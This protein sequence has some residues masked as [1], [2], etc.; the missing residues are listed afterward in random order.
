M[1]AGRL[2]GRQRAPG[3][4]T[5]ATPGSRGYVPSAEEVQSVLGRLQSKPAAP[6]EAGGKV[7]QRPVTHLRQE[8][9]D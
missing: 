8:L 5:M 1:L 6:M 9:L 4:Q 2:A 3:A 7:G